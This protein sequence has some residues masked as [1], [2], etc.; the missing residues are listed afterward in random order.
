MGNEEIIKK[1]E[2]EG[3]LA[4]EEGN[5]L[6]VDLTGD[7]N[8]KEGL[9]RLKEALVRFGHKKSYGVRYKNIY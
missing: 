3:F 2:K 8:P 1:L 4:H 6:Y 5:M 7:D 9:K